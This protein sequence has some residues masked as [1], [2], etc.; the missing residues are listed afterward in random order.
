VPPFRMPEGPPPVFPVLLERREDMT[1]DIARFELVAPEGK[2]LPPFAAGAHVDVVIAPEYL[3]QYSLAG[4]PADRSK[5]VIG[6]LREPQGRGGSA[7]MHRAFHAG[8]R[9]FIS[10][11]IN[12]FPLKEGATRSYL[13]AGG[14]GVTPLLTMAHRLHAI[15]AAF[16][17][18]YSAHSRTTAGFLA[19]IDAAPWNDRVALH[20]T[21]EGGRADFARLL[22]A[23]AAGFHLYTCGS[24]RYMDGVYAVAA[25]KGWPD[26]ALHRE[27]FSVPEPPDYVNHPFM[28]KLARSGR[29]IEVPAERSATEVL[30]E[31]GIHVEV[32]CSDGIC[33]TCAVRHLQ[34]EIEH[35]DYVLSAKEREQKIILCCSRA[36]TPNGK[37]VVDL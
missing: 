1:P 28:L 8:R 2:E 33:G 17:L 10:P 4:D 29:S 32:K 36:R 14:I 6:L 35:R 26:E 27:Y 7:L 3:R 12:Q 19:D 9:V 21:D 11:P 15:G 18:H 20:I 25:A 34:G 22:P 23:Y 37:I 13:F 24:A 31:A 16:E 5:Y 30:E